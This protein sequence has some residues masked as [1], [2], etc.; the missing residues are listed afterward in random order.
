[1]RGRIRW[2]LIIA[3]P[4]L[5]SFVFLRQHYVLSFRPV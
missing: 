5:I 2:I 1:M 3:G 4:A